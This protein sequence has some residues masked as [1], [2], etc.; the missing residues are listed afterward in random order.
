MVEV[1]GQYQAYRAPDHD[2]GAPPDV[3]V[4][5]RSIVCHDLD[6]STNRFGS[7]SRSIGTAYVDRVHNVH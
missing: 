2:S 7:C 1:A 6:S 3:G 4:H 5:S